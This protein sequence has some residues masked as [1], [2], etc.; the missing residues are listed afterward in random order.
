MARRLLL[1][2]TIL[3]PLAAGAHAAESPRRSEFDQYGGWTRLWQPPT[4][5]FHIKIVQGRLWLI[6]PLG[7]A[8]LWR[9]I[10][11]LPKTM[12]Q[13]DAVAGIKALGFNGAGPFVSFP[14]GRSG[15][16]YIVSLDVAGH[17]WQIRGKQPAG[18]PDVFDPDFERAAD[19]AARLQCGPRAADLWLVGYVTDTDLSWESALFD[20][21]SWPDSS[22]GKQAI[23]GRL[24]ERYSNQLE[25]FNAA[26]GLHLADFDSLLKE[27]RLEPGPGA[28]WD[29]VQ[30]D[31]EAVMST[32]AHRYFEVVQAA[33]RRYDTD[34]M[35]LGCRFSGRV[36]RAVALAMQ[37]KASAIYLKPATTQ[38]PARLIAQL[39]RDTG[40]AVLC[41]QP[42][43]VREA[44][45]L[46]AFVAAAART[47]TVIGYAWPLKWGDE[48]HLPLP[49]TEAADLSRA[50]AGYFR[51]A[52]RAFIP[53]GAQTDVPRYDARRCVRE[54]T[55]DGDLAD[56]QGADRLPLQV[57][58]YIAEQA[59]LEASV[60]LMWDQGHIYISGRVIDRRRKARTL[61]AFVKQDSLELTAGERRYL[62]TLRPGQQVVYRLDKPE[63]RTP[64]PVSVRPIEENGEIVGYTFEAGV[65]VPIL[66]GPGFVVRAGLRFRASGAGSDEPV[67]LSFP[68]DLIPGREKTEGE[69]SLADAR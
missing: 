51:A 21:M 6:D 37:G 54:P 49:P 68:A 9:G 69:F 32:L 24:K 34:H 63:E 60:A 7:N 47:P 53:I 57:S 62:A 13:E 55:I 38:I 52:A 45:S 11:G 39:Y 46:S 61:T 2:F 36:P 65:A 27:Q 33:I 10:S 42:E 8:F 64:Q 17:Y 43:Q 40:L 59:P 4:G 5:Y 31:R 58:P 14:P 1:I 23:V 12:A 56:W 44:E 22:P 26:W 3:L 35:M 66:V 28:D 29:A 15:I 16:A 30:S 20:C 25:K 41:D 50:N 48:H 19:E 18:F 67:F